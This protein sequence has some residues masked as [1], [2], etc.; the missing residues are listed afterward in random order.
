[1][2]DY[3]RDDAMPIISLTGRGA[4]VAV[5]IDNID[6]LRRAAMLDPDE[7]D[8]IA[9]DLRVASDLAR[10]ATRD[11]GILGP[12]VVVGLEIGAEPESGVEFDVRVDP[13]RGYPQVVPVKDRRRMVR[14]DVLVSEE[15]QA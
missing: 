4:R 12:A 9:G 8:A 6:R 10:Q 7:A 13:G 1:V 5:E 3:L 2:S 15:D 11:G 14:I